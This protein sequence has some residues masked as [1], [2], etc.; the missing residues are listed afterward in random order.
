MPEFLAETY[1]PCDMPGTAAPHAGDI[2]LAAEQVSRPEALVRFLRAIAVPDEE[3]CLYL[4][5]APGAFC[6]AMTRARLRPER[7]TRAVSVRPPNTRHAG[8]HLALVTC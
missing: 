3:A 2:A 8:H 6:K 7:I 4:F 5:Q 1:T